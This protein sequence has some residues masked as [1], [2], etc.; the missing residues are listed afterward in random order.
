MY[1]NRNVVRILAVL[2]CA[3]AAWGQAAGSGGA[4]TLSNVPLLT[5]F[6]NEHL[7]GAHQD[8]GPDVTFS[9]KDGHITVLIDGK[10]H[11][12][13]LIETDGQ[14]TTFKNK[15]GQTIARLLHAGDSLHIQRLPTVNVQSRRLIGVT[16]APVDE[17]LA[18]HI[19]VKSDECTLVTG[20][21]DGLG[22]AKAG[23]K[24][25]DVIVAVDGVKPATQNT[26]RHVIAGK[27]DDKIRID[28]IREGKPKQVVVELTKQ[29]YASATAAGTTARQPDVT[30]SYSTDIARQQLALADQAA[31]QGVERE[32][33]VAELRAAEALRDT[34]AVQRAELTKR[35]TLAATEEAKKRSAAEIAAVQSVLKDREAQ[36]AVLAEQLAKQK[37]VEAQR[38]QQIGQNLDAYLLYSEASKALTTAG[39]MRVISGQGVTTTSYPNVSD[40]LDRIEN[41]LAKIEELLAKL[42][43]QRE[44]Q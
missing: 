27:S 25:G 41:R 9:V 19:G 39:D 7:M 18:R 44:R 3:P 43:A 23:V 30:T 10:P 17:T 29:T 31:V 6:A 26:I 33:L 36:V 22:A 11:P 37:A 2:A 35:L 1:A 5:Y 42:A 32:R 38:K 13:E 16:L 4:T 14:V 40:R 8:A 21:T 24:A 15:D 20:V 34:L 12:A 28:L